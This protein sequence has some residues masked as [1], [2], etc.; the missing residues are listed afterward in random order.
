MRLVDGG[1][2]GFTVDI[3]ED[4]PQEHCNSILQG[5][6]TV[7][8]EF[9]SHLFKATD[10]QASLREVTVSLPSSW[11]TN[12]PTC[13]LFG[14]L[15]KVSNAIN[16]HMHVTGN[17]PV[18]GPQPW[19]QQSQGCGHPGDFIQ[20][21]ADILMDKENGT[22][23]LTAHS[24]VSQWA[25]F[26]WG[27][28]DEQGYEG[29]ILYPSTFLDPE[30]GS[31]RSNTCMD[32]DEESF[33]CKTSE[34]GAHT[35]QN[36]L[37]QGRSA[38]EIIMES[39][40]FQ[41]NIDDRQNISTSSLTPSINFVQ[42]SSQR[43]IIAVDNTAVM[44]M[45]N[46]WDILR[47]SVRRL[48]V[49]DIPD[50]VKLGLVVFNSKA[51]TTAPVTTLEENSDVRARIGSSLP[52]NPSN[53]PGS[54]KCIICGLK[55]AIH[56]FDA[57]SI[58]ISGG[59]VI[60]ITTDYDP[61]FQHEIEEMIKLTRMKNVKVDLISYPISKSIIDKEQTFNLH[62][63]V[64]ATSGAVTSVLDE[65]NG[66]Q[67]RIMLNLMDVLLSTVGHSVPDTPKIIH[68]NNHI[69]GHI[70]MAK[71]SFMLDDSI[72]K[73][74][75]LAVYYDD[76]NH[77]GN[78]IQLTTPSGY[79]MSNF[80]MQ[81]EDRDAN[82]IFVN[83][84]SAERGKWFY[85]VENRA[86]SEESIYVQVTAAQSNMR[87]TSLRVWTSITGTSINASDPINPVI[88]YAEVK[89]SGMPV[90]NARVIA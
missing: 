5:L 30:D 72:G 60:L 41:N 75:R 82:A 19:V 26:R 40:D 85:E 73:D 86:D 39:E 48:I 8:L 44:N 59:T 22:H 1:Y 64:F 11:Q 90:L 47:K 13:S 67:M 20:M 27:V 71:G 35:K 21:G 69:G 23:I 37:C 31:I 49:H 53:I 25:K 2:E 54:D 70:S 32:K 46:R 16:S 65:S 45:G 52:R 61:T 38:W 17:H 36:V 58:D 50:G 9:S 81:E 88:I 3:H 87:Q 15:T 83:I 62:N 18:F 76:I 24:L 6:K 28:F 12:T 63:L 56:A 57:D 66:S 7:L 74:A 89:E 84:P 77:I 29:D 4:L 80:N 33:F 79:R 14:P 55:E 10:G 42:R 78:V 51:I 34:P 43:I 68:S